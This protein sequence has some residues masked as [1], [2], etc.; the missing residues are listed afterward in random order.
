MELEEVN[1]LYYSIILT[2][3][4]TETDYNT[5]RLLLPKILQTLNKTKAAKLNKVTSIKNITFSIQKVFNILNKTN[6]PK[7]EKDFKEQVSLLAGVCL[8]L[9]KLEDMFVI[10]D[11]ALV[12]INSNPDNKPKLDKEQQTEV[13]NSIIAS[14]EKTEDNKDKEEDRPK[15]V[16]EL[17]GRNSVRFK[18]NIEKCLKGSHSLSRDN[19]T[20]T[21]LNGLK[22]I[23]QPYEVLAGGAG[24]SVAKDLSNLTQEEFQDF[25]TIMKPIETQIT[26]LRNRFSTATKETLQDILSK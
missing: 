23:A 19:K 1:K 21:F 6:P 25:S 17:L 15:K 20:M 4:L 14:A 2:E 5:L 24:L 7:D 8:S 3:A 9:F 26:D 12:E 18:S 10:V 16:S 22:T 13:P 11:K